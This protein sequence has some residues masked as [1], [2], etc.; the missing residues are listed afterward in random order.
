M[1]L[2]A[3]MSRLQLFTS[4]YGNPSIAKSGL[5]PVSIARYFPRFR[6]P[7]RID[8]TF[9]EVAPTAR[10]LARRKSGSLSLQGFACEYEVQLA[11][12]GLTRIVDR[13]EHLQGQ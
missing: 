12:L 5:V 7:Y 11:T 8:A 13:L 10:M 2:P 9:G 3:E 1:R 6:L 4:R